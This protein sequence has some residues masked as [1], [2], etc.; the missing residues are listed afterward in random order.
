MEGGSRIKAR[1]RNKNR[2]AACWDVKNSNKGSNKRSNKRTNKRS[3]KRIKKIVETA[4]ERCVKNHSRYCGKGCNKCK[5]DI[6]HGS[7][8]MNKVRSVRFKEDKHRIIS[9]V[10]APQTNKSANR[11]EKNERQKKSRNNKY[12]RQFNGYK[13][14]RQKYIG[15]EGEKKDEEKKEKKKEGEEDGEGE[16]EG[17]ERIDHNLMSE[18]IL[19]AK[20]ALTTAAR[21]VGSVLSYSCGAILSGVGKL[22]V[23]GASALQ[24]HWSDRQI[25]WEEAQQQTAQALAIRTSNSN[26]WREQHQQHQQQQHQQHQQY[27]RILWDNACTR[28]QP[29]QLQPC[30]L[31]PHQSQLRS[32]SPFRRIVAKNKPNATNVVKANDS[33]NASNADNNTTVSATNEPEDNT[34]CVVCMAEPRTH[35]FLCGHLCICQSCAVQLRERRCPV[36]R[37]DGEPFMIYR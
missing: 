23:H 29:R 34:I 1:P 11:G 10:N 35:S 36:C 7:A 6:R 30:Q 27:Q 28:I 20:S 19:N 24:R 16:G 33:S 32:V 31:Q 13:D 17:E 12:L 26:L 3:N 25:A 9:P 37:R 4:D 2:Q 14:I 15:N 5:R 22:A 8:N 21:V 18:K